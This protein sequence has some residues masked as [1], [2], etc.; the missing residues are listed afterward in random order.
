MKVSK[1]WLGGR[2]IENFTGDAMVSKP[3][4]G[5]NFIEINF[6]WVSF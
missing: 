6:V 2:A 3:M 4:F 5:I 1:K